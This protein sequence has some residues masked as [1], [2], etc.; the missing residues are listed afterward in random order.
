MPPTNNICDFTVQFT[1]EQKQSMLE[2]AGG[3]PD[4]DRKDE[5]FKELST[6]ARDYV[7][8]KSHGKPPNPSDIEHEFKALHNAIKKIKPVFFK[9]PYILQVHNYLVRGIYQNVDEDQAQ[10]GNPELRQVAGNK[11]LE[12][13]QNLILLEKSVD[14]VMKMLQEEKAPKKEARQVDELI[15]TLFYRLYLVWE[16]YFARNPHTSVGQFIRFVKKFFSAVVASMP[17]EFKSSHRDIVSEL[18]KGEASIRYRIKQ[19]N[20]LLLASAKPHRQR[21]KQKPIFSVWR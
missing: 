5:L 8:F 6:I 3:L 11:M 1:E 17:T 14:S 4:Q 19:I 18:S 21:K 12:I 10:D 2:A 15:Q 16:G 7:I 20:A 9:G 13:V